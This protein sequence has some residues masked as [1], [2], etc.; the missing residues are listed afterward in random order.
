M[1]D[2]QHRVKDFQAQPA[3]LGLFL[4]STALSAINVE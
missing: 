3:G 1:G 2:E 4:H